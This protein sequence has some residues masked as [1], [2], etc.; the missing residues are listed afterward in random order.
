MGGVVTSC[1]VSFYERRGVRPS[2]M[3]AFDC[4]ALTLLIAGALI[5]RKWRRE[6]FGD[7]HIDL[8]TSLSNAMALFR[9]D[10]RIILVGAVQSAFE[11]AMYL[12]VFMWTMAL[13]EHR[14][15]GAIDHGMVFAV[16]MESCLVGATLS[17]VLASRLS[18]RT[19][20]TV[21]ALCVLAALAL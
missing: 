18:W 9:S 21:T 8:R 14:G 20:K 7:A 2:E 4:S 10:R 5:T 15:D 19:E 12:F 6:N 3:A 1:A 16:F 17:G 11:S 13:E